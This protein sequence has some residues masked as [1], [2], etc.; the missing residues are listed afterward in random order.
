MSDHITSTVGR[1]VLLACIAASLTRAERLPAKVYTTA[2]GLA[3][4]SVHR[5]VCDS[6][7]LLW[8]CTG[9]GLSRFDG[10][11]FKN[12]GTAE[13]L[14]DPHVYDIL[15]TRSGEYWVAT[16]GGPVPLRGQEIGPAGD[17]RVQSP[18]AP[19]SGRSRSARTCRRAR[20]N[21]MGGNLPRT[22]PVCSWSRRGIVS[23]P[24]SANF[25]IEMASN[26]PA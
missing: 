25:E 5:I 13:G 15:E 7:G 24:G 10:Y 21:F 4:N 17:N 1:A 6:R 26:G 12:Y 22:Q 19:T 16:A 20:R 9:E 3:H 18:R 8:F 11:S 14:P 2:D 23:T